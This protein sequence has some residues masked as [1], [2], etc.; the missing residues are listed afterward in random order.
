LKA[1]NRHSSK[2]FAL[3]AVFLLLTLFTSMLGAYLFITRT[4]LQLIK[5]SRDS[6]SGFNVA[7][8]GLNLRA[9]EIRSVFFALD[10]PEGSAPV[11][12]LNGCDNGDIGSGD[13]ACKEYSFDNSHKAVT[14]VDQGTEL[15][16][17][18]PGDEAFGGLFATE[19]RYTATS[20]GRNRQSENEAVLEMT[21][22]ARVVP[23][24]QFAIFFEQDLE[25]FNGADMVVTGPVHSNNDAYFAAQDGGSLSFEEEVTVANTLYRGVKSNPDCS[26]YSGPVKSLDPVTYKNFDSCSSGRAKVTD[27]SKWNDNVLKNVG[28]VQV[29]SIDSIQSFSTSPYWT[30]ADARIVLRLNSSNQPDTTNSS[31]GIEVVDVD[32]NNIS[33]ATDALDNATGCPG[34]VNTSSSSGKAVGTQGPGTSGDQLR[35]YR[36]YQW[37]SS[38]NNTQRT[39]EV[40]MEALFDCIHDFDVVMEGKNLDDETNQGLVLFFAIDGPDSNAPQNNYSVRLRNGSKL[41]ASDS[42]APLP[43]GMSLIT[44]QSLVLWGDL[45]S[46]SKIPVAL[47]SDSQYI[48]SNQWQDSDSYISDVWN[49]NAQHLTVQAAILTGVQ[50]TG[51]I[52][53]PGGQDAGYDTNG[54]GVI[55]IFRFNEWFR[56]DSSGTHPDFTYKGSLVSLGPPKHSQST[57]GPFTYYSAPNRIWSFDKDFIVPENL[58][59]LT[60]VF[61]YLKQEVFVRDYEV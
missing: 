22:K 9:A 56:L 6:A 17:T 30:K 50:H 7:E 21:F 57:W 14:Y 19:Y 41:Q 42:S 61:V 33:A 18:I 40:D 46:S 47:F 25:F 13:Y 12:G 1:N 29:P 10:Y 53:G 52:N 20:V 51:G 4:D 58:P 49:R 37:D 2:G 55:N 38:T 11:D 5:A 16:I 15:N 3:V 43:V 27:T 54:G 35:L 39:L 32:G 26:G 8:A 44:D 60:P 31:T 23:L 28:S 45:N 34:S 59:P 24:F 36:E 48:L